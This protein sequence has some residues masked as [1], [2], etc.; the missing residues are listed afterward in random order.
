[1][2]RRL[3]VATR[4]KGPL[5]V[6][7]IYEED[8]QWDPEWAPLQG[9]ALGSLFSRVSQA[10]FHHVLHGF[11]RPFVD[12]LGL[13][14]EGALRKLP[15]QLCLRRKTCTLHDAKKCVASHPKLPWCYVPAGVSEDEKVNEAAAQAVFRWRERVYLV[16]V[17]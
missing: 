12:S 10:N 13:P 4:E 15:S 14:P 8:G 7:A 2:L 17:T 1:M 5:E 11:S 16:V 3:R 6:L 9:T